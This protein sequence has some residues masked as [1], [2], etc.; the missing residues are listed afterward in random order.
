[1]RAVKKENEGDSGSTMHNSG[2]TLTRKSYTRKKRFSREVLIIH[3]I[4][5]RFNSWKFQ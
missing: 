5:F 1:M 2:S 3:V 4:N